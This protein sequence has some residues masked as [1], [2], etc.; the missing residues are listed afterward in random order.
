MEIQLR[1]G[2][3]TQELATRRD[4]QP[5]RRLGARVDE[6]M[7]TDRNPSSPVLDG[8]NQA[9]HSNSTER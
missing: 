6:K 2:L 1:D 5:R 9:T 7:K 4:P 3:R 8:V